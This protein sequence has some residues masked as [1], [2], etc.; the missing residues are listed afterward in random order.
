M[1]E[2]T[3]MA[4]GPSVPEY[5][6]L[7]APIVAATAGQASQRFV[8][9]EGWYWEIL[10]YSVGVV[11]GA[12]VADQPG[13][14]SAERGTVAM[15]QTP[16]AVDLPIAGFVGNVTWARDAVGRSTST[17]SA[18]S[19]PIPRTIVQGG[20][21][22]NAVFP[23]AGNVLSLDEGTLIA[24]AVAPIARVTEGVFQTSPV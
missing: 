2:A 22:V 21:F 15:W 7:T 1:N 14:F 12:P 17:P 11:V 9:P 8:L 19:T 24:R 3:H 4:P 6:V 16:L 18:S 20:W 5:L 13:L 10:S 23:I